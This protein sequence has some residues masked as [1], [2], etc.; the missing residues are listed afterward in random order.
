MSMNQ[1]K[2]MIVILMHLK[3]IGCSIIMSF[4]V[5]LLM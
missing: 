2:I 3:L 1:L 4:L 5:V